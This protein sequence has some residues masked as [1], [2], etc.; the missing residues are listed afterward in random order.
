MS[1]TRWFIEKKS[2]YTINKYD[3]LIYLLGVV[4]TFIWFD[5]L[6]DCDSFVQIENT[7]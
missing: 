3:Y 7:F 6:Y 1:A 5:T 4:R 2:A